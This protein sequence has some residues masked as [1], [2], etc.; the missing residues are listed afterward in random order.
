MPSQFHNTGNL[1]DIAKH[2][3]LVA[4]ADAMARQ[5]PTAP[6]RYLDT[7]AFILEAPLANVRWAAQ[8]RPYAERYAPYARYGALQRAAVQAGTY[9]CSAGLLA[10]LWP[11]A[12]FCLSER[13]ARLRRTLAQQLA[14]RRLEDVR[15]RADAGAWTEHLP[16]APDRALLALID[17]FRLTPLVWQA[18]QGALVRGCAGDLGGAALVFDYDS[19]LQPAPWPQPPAGWCGPL[20]QWRRAPFALTVYATPQCAPWVRTTMQDLAWELLT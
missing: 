8:L 13:E 7:H 11:S 1:G 2:T 9:Q 4:L 3:A 10:R 6:K 19:A 17:P 12:Q 16:V 20:A 14:A 5:L 18:V 15:V